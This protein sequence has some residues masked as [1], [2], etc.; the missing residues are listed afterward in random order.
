MLDEERHIV[1]LSGKWISAKA[2]ATSFSAT[3][4]LDYIG[5]SSPVAI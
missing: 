2:F 5:L 3:K 4:A 1:A